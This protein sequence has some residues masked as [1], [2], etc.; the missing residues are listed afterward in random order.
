MKTWHRRKTG[1]Q[2]NM[3]RSIPFALLGLAAS[4]PAF[5]A[6]TT[7]VGD[8]AVYSKTDLA[9]QDHLPQVR[10]VYKEWGMP[11]VTS[12]EKVMDA[13]KA[14]AAR[15]AMSGI[16][17]TFSGMRREEHNGLTAMF[18]A[19][20]AYGV[21]LVDASDENVVDTLKRFGH[22]GAIESDYALQRATSQKIAGTAPALLA[23][24]KNPGG[25]P[26]DARAVHAYAAILGQDA[27]PELTKVLRFHANDEA[28]VEAG[29]ELVKLG[30]SPVVQ[31]ALAS[32][33]SDTVK[34]SLQHALLQ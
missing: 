8:I 29:I 6:D 1:D 5:S 16:V 21:R 31:E 25:K 27:V 9:Q 34:R 18:N 10:K 23:Y 22:V 14:D 15:D 33:H 7:S 2:I 3:L 12:Q 30:A 32:E 17:V 28:R 19:V 4:I 24:I 26:V 20:D 11:L 13:V